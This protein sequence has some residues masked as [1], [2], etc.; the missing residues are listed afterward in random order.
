MGIQN[1][2]IRKPETFKIQILNGKNTKW[3]PKTTSLDCFKNNFSSVQIKWSRL[4]KCLVFGSPLYVVC[5]E[6]RFTWMPLMK[7]FLH[8]AESLEILT[9][10]KGSPDQESLFT[11]LSRCR[12]LTGTS[13]RRLQDRTLARGVDSSVS[14][15]VSES[16]SDSTSHSGSLVLRAAYS[17]KFSFRQRCF[18]K[19][20]FWKKCSLD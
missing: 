5:Q 11:T 17:W 4:R 8:N 3:Q 16:D 12:T 18:Q 13:L 6:T 19:L 15:L 10:W 20:P 1:P 7:I 9:S 14:L 2:T